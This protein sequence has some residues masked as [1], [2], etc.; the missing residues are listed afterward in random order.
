VTRR[1][2]TPHGYQGMITD[3]ELDV[4]RSAVWSIDG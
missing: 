4:P 2:Y 1:I 3:H